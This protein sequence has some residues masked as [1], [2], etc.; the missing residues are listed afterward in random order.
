MGLDHYLPRDGACGYP[1]FNILPVNLVPACD[2]CNDNGDFRDAAGR[3]AVIHPYFDGIPNVRLLF[4]DVSVVRDVPEVSFRVD[5]SQCADP[6]FAALFRRHVALFELEDLYQTRWADVDD[7]LP[8][9]I[10]MLKALLPGTDREGMR[11]FLYRCA[12]GKERDLGPN[13]FKVVLYR[14]AAASDDFLDLCV[15]GGR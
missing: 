12:K 3:R 5:V 7:G 9:V 10:N 8:D 4:A 6:E 11:D 13:D 2:R 15:G 1:E 14:G